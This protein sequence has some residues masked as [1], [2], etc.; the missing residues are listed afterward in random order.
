MSVAAPQFK[1]Q[2]SEAWV[3][4]YAAGLHVSLFVSYVPLSHRR[5]SHVSYVSHVS[6]PLRRYVARPLQSPA[7]LA[8]RSG[9]AILK[10][11]SAR[12]RSTEMCLGDC[13]A[14]T[15]FKFASLAVAR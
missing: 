1:V 4:G 10:L 11:I 12:W 5:P 14:V 2:S 6:H 3:G 15:S 7:R 8:P 9:Y 13:V